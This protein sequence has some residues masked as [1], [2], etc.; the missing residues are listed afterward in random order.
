MKPCLFK[1]ELKALWNDPWQ[2]ALLTYLPIVALV[3]LGWIFTSAMPREL[4]VAIVDLDQS[5]LSRQLAFELQASPTI[6]LQTYSDLAAA[7]HAMQ[8][9]DMYAMVVI[10]QGMRKDLLTGH[11]PI[12]DVRYNSQFLLVGKLLSSQI[13]QA[14]AAGL[15]Q[16]SLSSQLSRGVPKAQAEINVSPIKQQITPLHNFN[17]HYQVFLMPAILVALGQIVVML[18]CLNSFA[19]ELRHNAVSQWLAQGAFYGLWVK[20]LVYIPLSVLQLAALNWALYLYLGVDISAQLPLLLLAQ[21]FMAIA[22]WLVVTAVFMLLKD[23]A[24]AVSFCAAMYAPAFPFMGVT[25]PTHD[26]PFVAQIW[27]LV[28]PSSYYIEQHLAIVSSHINLGQLLTMLSGYLPFLTL[29]IV[30]ALGV[31]KLAQTNAKEPI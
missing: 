18:N 29:L 22:I 15:K 28:M 8:Q 20:A 26:M 10:P 17:S 6:N 13:Q 4:P 23:S 16:V 27:R 11:S 3:L 30:I 7:K 21:L 14:L 9:V 24:R 2:L 25:F 5:Q 31:T 1:R 12:I 19:R